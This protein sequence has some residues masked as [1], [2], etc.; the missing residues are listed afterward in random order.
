ME[1]NLI[2]IDTFVKE[3]EY[4]QIEKVF[5]VFQ[6]KFEVKRNN[7]K[8]HFEVYSSDINKFIYEMLREYETKNSIAFLV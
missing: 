1:K 8:K 7:R 6:G 4:R 2:L 5:D 3:E